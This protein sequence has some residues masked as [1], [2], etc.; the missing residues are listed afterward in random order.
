MPP[1]ISPSDIRQAQF[2]T[3]LRGLDRVEVEQ[4]LHEV[5]DR[6]EELEREVAELKKAL[7]HRPKDWSEEFDTLGR[8][9][10]AI[11][12]AA[13]E[14][15]ETMR[16]KA[17]A[18]AARW[19]SEA[20]QDAETARREA[21]ADAEALRRDAWVAGTALLEQAESEARRMRE[22]AERDV[23][24]VMGEAERE[25]HRLT[26][27]ARREAEDTI[28]NA[29]MAAEKM[30]AEAERRRDDIIE[31][32]N[33]QAA[34][35]QER[36]R[37][38]EQRRDELL[39]ELENVRATLFKLEESLESKRE[40]LQAAATQPPA[41]ESTS[42]KVVQPPKDP[43]WEMGE[44]VRVVPGES[45]I[46]K[47]PAESP[48]V[49]G[50]PAP[51][52]IVP[53]DLDESVVIVRPSP[54]PPAAGEEPAG[55][56]ETAAEEPVVAETVGEPSP[57]DS[58][59][60]EPPLEEPAGQEVSEEPAGEEVAD[61]GGME[62][63]DDEPDEPVS[64]EEP[65]AGEEPPVTRDD[66]DISSLF[67]ALKSTAHQADPAE[68]PAEPAPAEPVAEA[69][70]AEDETQEPVRIDG[71][72]WIEERDARLLPIT[73]RALRGT[74]KAIT[75]LQNI[76]LDQ[77]R[78]DEKWRPDPRVVAEAIGADLIAL[79]AESFAAGHAVAEAMTGSKLKRPPT[80]HSGAVEEVS[81][82]LAEDL[83]RALDEAGE[84]TR[85]RQSAASKVFRVWR[86]DEAEQRLRALAIR[87]YEQGVEKSIATL[88]S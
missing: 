12:Q 26:S 51:E 88:D 54:K 59:V 53:D 31:A 33:K 52:R 85:E 34:A 40:Q 17:A 3:V 27:A 80:P 23:L 55:P 63:V 65:A 38:L 73:N 69:E 13:H 29:T 48:A 72:D 42:V 79:W 14:A 82:A 84:G 24:T 6:F 77:L 32:A 21:L 75:E 37:A 39:E 20:L 43:G 87:A 76:A 41:V 7:E 81:A 58:A 35:A 1:E 36:T 18:D 68:E 50:I 64:A 44:T 15:A 57:D 9:V 74:K 66:D 5:A 45:R 56:E 28:R 11:L 10:T 19:R 47:L 16:E 70:P 22:Q 8:E 78:T 62:G 67:A 86:S 83:S 49:P 61:A 30:T 25:A 71:H 46:P 2:R 60:G 4:F